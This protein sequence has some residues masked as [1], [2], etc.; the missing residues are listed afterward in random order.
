MKE[1][2]ERELGKA[3]ITELLRKEQESTEQQNRMTILK[4]ENSR[5]RQTVME[6]S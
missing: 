2:V 5:Y 6:K 4:K 3:Q 1:Q